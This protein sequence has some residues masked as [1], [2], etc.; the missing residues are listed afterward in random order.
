MK[1]LVVDDD[2]DISKLV[3]TVL[4]QDGHDIGT[5]SS[6]AKALTA[7]LMAEYDLLICDLMLPDLEGT[8]IIRAL[9]AQ[10]PRLPVIAM[11]ALSADV[12]RDACTEAGASCLLQKPIDLKRLRFE[13][14]LVQKARLTLAIALVDPDAIHRIRMQKTLAALGCE[15]ATFSNVSAA[16]Q[17]ITAQSV[18]QDTGLI[19]I[20]A[21]AKDA[22]NFVHWGKG[23]NIPAF[24]FA[25]QTSDVS[26]DHMLRSGA[27]FM[28]QKPVDMDTLLTQAGFLLA[29]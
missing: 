18:G 17:S 27:A 24:V 11:S 20:D 3:S 12:W 6:G 7:A 26:E 2:A 10:S 9:K 1:I 28:L 22:A 29:G 14:T 13:V 8:E 21:D 4:S 16:Q 19:V 5:A 25:G 15:V 23:R